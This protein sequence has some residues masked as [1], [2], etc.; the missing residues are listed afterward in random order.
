MKL[1]LQTMLSE[2]SPRIPDGWRWPGGELIRRRAI[3]LV[4]MAGAQVV[5]E[6]RAGRP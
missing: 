5:W 4:P 2:L 6:Q 1:M 3:T